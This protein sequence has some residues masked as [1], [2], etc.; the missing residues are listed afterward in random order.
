MRRNV[1]YINIRALFHTLFSYIVLCQSKC[2]NLTLA[3]KQQ[4]TWQHLHDL[5]GVCVHV[6]VYK[7]Y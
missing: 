4:Q 5:L 7:G 6:S 1:C 3:N 2:H